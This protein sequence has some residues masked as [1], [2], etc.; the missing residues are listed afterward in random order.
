MGRGGSVSPQNGT[1]LRSKALRS[2]SDTSRSPEGWFSGGFQGQKKLRQKFGRN[3]LWGRAVDPA[4][5]AEYGSP[6]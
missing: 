6:L 4:L 5:R 3:S 1:I 2:R